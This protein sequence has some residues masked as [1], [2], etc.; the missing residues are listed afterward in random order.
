MTTG[1]VLIVD[2]DRQMCELIETDLR[3]RGYEARWCQSAADALRM[4]RELNFDVVL[5]DVRMPG[6]S[7]L[8]LCDELQRTRPDLPVVVMTAFGSMETAVAAMRAGAYDFITKPVELDMLALTIG[9]AVERSQLGRQ[10]KLLSERREAPAG[11]GEIIGESPA[12]HRV[13]DQLARVADSDTS[14]LI[15]GES[16]M[17]KELV[18]RSIHQRSSRADK[19]FVA[20][21]CAALSEGLLESELFGH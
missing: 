4:I 9:R 19:P 5:S 13:Y 18:A 12:M 6:T 8:Q 1:S 7:G 15:T 14:V 16:G 11:F 10:V 20:I 2:D 3:L 21:N 17:G